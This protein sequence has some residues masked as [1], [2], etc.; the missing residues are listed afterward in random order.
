MVR[1]AVHEQ[2]IAAQ[3]GLVGVDAARVIKGIRTSKIN[4]EYLCIERF[5]CILGDN[6]PR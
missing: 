4:P 1:Y 3:N 6:D 2:C 5:V